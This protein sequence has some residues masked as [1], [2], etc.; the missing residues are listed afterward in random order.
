MMKSKRPKDRTKI[1]Q[2]WITDDEDKILKELAQERGVTKTTLV[3]GW[4]QQGEPNANLPLPPSPR[5]RDSQLLKHLSLVRKELN[6]IGKN[7]NQVAKAL[8]VAQIQPEKTP[9]QEQVARNIAQI[10]EEL[11]Q[12]I[13]KLKSL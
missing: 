1:F 13:E 4:I 7:L 12:A 10:Q 5:Q 2:A 9:P 8:N 6:A 3:R 11:S